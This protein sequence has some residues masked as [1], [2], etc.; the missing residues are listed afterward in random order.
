MQRHVDPEFRAEQAA[1]VATLPEKEQRHLVDEGPA[2]VRGKARDL[3][4]HFSSATAEWYTPPEIIDLVLDVLGE[5]DLDPAS[6]TGKPNVPARRHYTKEDDGLS[7]P[8]AGRVFLNPPYGKGIAKWTERL[9]D[10]YEQG[11]VTAAIA[12]L[13]ARTDTAWFQ[14]LAKYPRCFLQGRLKFVGA[15]SSAPFP[16]MLV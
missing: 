6:N 10:E 5:I 16:S 9:C 14:G 13:P 2:A 3:K 11:A 15:K 4:A 1:E 8:W 7:Q 12:L